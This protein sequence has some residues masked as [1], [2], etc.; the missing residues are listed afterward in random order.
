MRE[1]AA[2]LLI[3]PA[4]LTA[5]RTPL[6]VGEFVRPPILRRDGG[7]FG[8]ACNVTLLDEARK[9]KESICLGHNGPY[10]R[11]LCL[12]DLR[13]PEPW[14][15]LAQIRMEYILASVQNGV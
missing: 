1:E 2:S 7:G 12:V 6:V 15:F 9:R 11:P 5:S 8:F 4:S 14:A 13:M 10:E 3:L